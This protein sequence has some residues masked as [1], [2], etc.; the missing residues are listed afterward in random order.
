MTGKTKPEQAQEAL[1]KTSVAEPTFDRAMALTW[2][3]KATRL[4]PT[5]PLLLKIAGPWRAGTGATGQPQW[6]L[7]GDGLLTPKLPKEVVWEG[8]AP[9]GS[10]LSLRYSSY[11]P[12]VGNLPVTLKRRLFLLERDGKAYRAIPVAAKD[13]LRTDALYLDEVVID[14]RQLQRFGLLEIALPPGAFMEPSTWGVRLLES[15]AL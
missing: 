3:A 15:D 11:A 5:D 1:V 2:L 6:T 12:E 13:T 7:P 10:S 4:T 9:A 8:A 14:S